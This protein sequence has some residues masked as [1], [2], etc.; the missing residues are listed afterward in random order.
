MGM[1]DMFIII[2]PKILFPKGKIRHST[3]MAGSLR[4]PM[5]CDVLSMRTFKKMK[6]AALTAATTATTY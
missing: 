3:Y 1:G 4:P 5:P 6:A 2:V